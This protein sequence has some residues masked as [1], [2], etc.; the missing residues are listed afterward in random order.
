MNRFLC[1]AGAS[2]LLHACVFSE[3]YT[4]HR[5]LSGNLA[6]FYQRSIFVPRLCFVP[7]NTPFSNFMKGLKILRETPSRSM[8]QSKVYNNPGGISSTSRHRSTLFASISDVGRH[9]SSVSSPAAM[10]QAAES[11]DAI[12]DAVSAIPLPGEEVLH[13]QL[14]LHHQKKR[15]VCRWYSYS[16]TKTK[17]YFFFERV[18]QLLH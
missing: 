13:F 1:L 4:G 17:A 18:S 8:A 9:E 6:S 3:V 14:Q 2:L 12:L 15:I 11:P 10:V 7:S 16:S 5:D